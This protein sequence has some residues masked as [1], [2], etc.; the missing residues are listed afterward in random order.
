[1]KYTIPDCGK[2]L[3]K[4]LLPAELDLGYW[5]DATN[6]RFRQGFAEKWDGA[7]SL[8]ASGTTV[9][10]LWFDVFNSPSATLSDGYIVYSDSDKV[11]AV[12]ALNGTP[13][14]EITRY[15]D[16]VGIASITRV[17]TT[18]TLT[19]H[20]AHG[21][22][23]GQSVVV[24]GASPAQYNGNFV[25]TVTGATTFTYT[26]G[27]DPG[28][29]ASPVG[30]F[31]YAGARLDFTAQPYSRW[32]GGQAGSLMILNNPADGLYYWD[33]NTAN[34]LFRV[35][36]TYSSIAGAFA[37]AYAARIFKNYVVLLRPGNSVSLS[38]RVQWS[39]SFEDGA[40]PTTFNSS[41]TNDAGFVDLTETS[42]ALVDACKLGDD[43]IVYKTDSRYSMQYIGGNAVFRFTRL[44]GEGGLINRHCVVDTPVGHVFMTPELDVKIHQGGEPKSILD[45]RVRSVLTATT[46][47]DDYSGYLFMAR[48]DDKKEVF[49]GVYSTVA[50]SYGLIW[51]WETQTW[52]VLSYPSGT[53][54][55]FANSALVP[56]S[57]VLGIGE[58]RALLLSTTRIPVIGGS[59]SGQG[60]IGAQDYR[61][62]AN[63]A[64]FEQ[65]ITGTLERIGMHLGDR[66]QMKSVQRS[67]WVIDGDAADTATIYHGSS[68]SADTAPTYSSGG[69]YTIGTTDFVNQR[70]T[71]GRYCAIKLST[72]AYPISI[73]S[74]DLDVISGGSR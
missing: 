23:T 69:T 15:T 46:T 41:A 61:F 24:Y 26:M 11:Y 38:S 14:V 2:G 25:I 20:T 21:R 10:P 59:P 8:L 60:D 63:G 62:G 64:L 3:I 42:G 45:G 17:G 56:S 31:L 54:I 48:N 51:N 72:T 52:G 44:P 34:A 73:R 19:T 43:L 9:Q 55:T 49:I 35:A 70:V 7:A 47:A 57:S 18:A 12:S 6:F 71:A 39:D 16:N 58:K 37:K 13:H 67:R 28:A 32:T 50:T 22:T 30:F 40:L 68:M 27:S 74:I 5:S 36:A 29:S 65:T 33:G 53:P 1:M 66:S 4:D